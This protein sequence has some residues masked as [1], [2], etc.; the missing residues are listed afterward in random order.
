MKF[1]HIAIQVEDI[2]ESISWYVE[3]LSAKILKEHDDWGM[4]LIDNLVLALTMPGKHPPHIAFEV[5][6]V[7]KFPCEPSEI[8][9]HRDGSFYYYQEVP[10]GT[11]IE[12]LFWPK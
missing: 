2:K 9:S 1:H 3:N 7:S 6:S 5:D 8:K 12:W 4:I 11:I 10:D